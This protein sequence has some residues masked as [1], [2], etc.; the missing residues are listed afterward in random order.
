MKAKTRVKWLQGSKTGQT[1]QGKSQRPGA[2][3]EKPVNEVKN[4][5]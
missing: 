3:L 2:K 5:L 4:Q 1:S